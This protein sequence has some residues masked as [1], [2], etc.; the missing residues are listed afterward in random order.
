MSTINTWIRSEVTIGN[1]KYT[2]G[3]IFNPVQITLG[4]DVVHIQRVSVADSTAT[5]LFDIADDIADFDF[6]WIESSQTGEVELVVAD[7]EAGVQLIVLPVLANLP[8]ILGG[9][10]SRESDHTE[11]FGTVGTADNIEKITFY[12]TSGSAANV[13]L[14]AFT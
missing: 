6:L 12:Q 10:N 1:Q 3:D 4:S 11:D 2:L 9:D 7:G 13:L 14:A 5:K 8:L